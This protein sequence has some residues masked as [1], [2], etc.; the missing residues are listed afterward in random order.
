[1]VLRNPGGTAVTG[2]LQVA[3]LERNIAYAWQGLDSV[4]TV[5]RA[6]L[7]DAAGEAVTIPAGDS[8]VKTR[9]F[10]I[11]AAWDAHKCDLVVFVQNNSTKEV[12][13]AMRE[14]V[15]PAPGIAFLKYDPVLPL[16]NS[17]VSLRVYL[18]NVGTGGSENVSATLTTADPYVEISTGTAG[19]G[20]IPRSGDGQ[21]QSDFQI[22]VAANCP[23]P[24]LATM[25]LAIAAD[26]YAA[27]SS[28]PLNITSVTGFSDGMENGDNGWSHAGTN[29]NWHQST[30]QSHAGTHAWYSGS[31]GS[32]QYTGENDARLVTPFFTM[33][34]SD[35]IAFYQWFATEPFFDYCMIEVSNGSQ[36]W[37]LLGNYNGSSS[38]WQLVEYPTPELG[39]QTVQVRFRFLS[40]YDIAAEGWYVDDFAGGSVMSVS[41]SRH[42]VAGHF[43]LTA[44]RNPVAD[45]A[46]LSYQVPAGKT[47]SLTI[48]DATGRLVA[49]LGDALQGPGRLNWQLSDGDSRA[50]QSGLYFACL[51]AGSDQTVTKVVVAR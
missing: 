29:D 1:M 41:D 26:G 12:F 43:G 33:G 51:H 4:Y 24:H 5:E 6:M 21:P 50:V 11:D 10:S 44:G 35:R 28:F 22:H 15:M 32:R 9:D 20:A 49:R 47:G 36:F 18:R 19:Y 25:D 2:Q 3:L 46:E 16:P 8:L 14:T 42:P 31:E 45:R 48:F 38:G 30:H 27:T 13:Q 7:P 23:D 17:D 37:Q 34:D 40:D 39:S